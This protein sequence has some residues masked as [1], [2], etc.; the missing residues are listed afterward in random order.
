[1]FFVAIRPG[2]Y[3]FGSRGLMERGVVGKIVVESG[4]GS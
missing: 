4:A 3:E 1:L 2:T